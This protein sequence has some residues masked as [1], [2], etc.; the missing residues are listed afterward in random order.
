MF[1]RTILLVAGVLI[2][3]NAAL[4]ANTSQSSAMEWIRPKSRDVVSPIARVYMLRHAQENKALVW[5]FFTD[6]GIYN[7]SQF[8]AAKRAH[9]DFFTARAAARRAKSGV[10]E[11]K[12]TDL[13]VIDDYVNGVAARGAELRHVSRWL[14]AASFKIAIDD[15]DKIGVLPFVSRIQPV[16]IYHNDYSPPDIPE[17]QMQQETAQGDHVLSYGGCYAQLRQIDV[18][19]C[20]DSGYYGQGVVISVFD[21]GFRKSHVAFAQAYAEG[22]VLAEWDFVFNDGNVANQ[23]G[24]TSAWDHGTSTW[25]IC[26]GQYAGKL[27]GP[28]Y[29]ASFILCKTEDIRSET[30]VEEDNWEAAMEWVDS[31]GTDIITS[32]LSYTDWYTYEDYDGNTCVTT[33]A[34]DIAAANGIIVCNSAGN[35]GPNLHTIGAPADADSIMAVGSVNIYGDISEFSSKGPTY[36]GRI[37]PEVCA[38]G[39]NNYRAIASSDLQFGT[40]ASGTSFSCPLVA[41]AAGVVLSA[42]PDWTNM[43]VRQALMKTADRGYSPNHSYGWGII[44]TWA[45]IHYVFVD[46][47]GDAD[48]NGLVN[49]TDAVFLVNYVFAG[50]DP[51]DPLNAGD[52]NDSGSVNVSDVVFLI[53]YIF[54]GGPAPTVF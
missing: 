54:G 49:V 31:I 8:Q 45:A 48:R 13:P 46:P 40:G 26:G 18:P 23:G 4:F 32:S 16:A 34:A 53:N 7:E 1:R 6:K 17:K 25:S 11:L 21:S 10:T 50:G 22:R 9:S 30:Q 37:K 44:D 38:L 43:Q 12:F 19:I 2:L 27:Y 42:H 14:N 39:E 24:E 20:H 52:A 5:V 29:G 3:L 41:G 15:L 47:P 51:P 35:Y 33:I 36:D 28:S